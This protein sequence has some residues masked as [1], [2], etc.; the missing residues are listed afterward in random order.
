MLCP[1]DKE[2]RESE[3]AFEAT[4]LPALYVALPGDALQLKR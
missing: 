4:N 3:A 2:G 1:L